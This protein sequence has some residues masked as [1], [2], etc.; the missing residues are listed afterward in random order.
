MVLGEVVCGSAAGEGWHSGFRGG[1]TG[2]GRLAQLA[3]VSRLS[4][5]ICIRGSVLGSALAAGKQQQWTR[6]ERARLYEAVNN[7]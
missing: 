3:D 4:L 6:A 5:S 1:G 7:V 2:G